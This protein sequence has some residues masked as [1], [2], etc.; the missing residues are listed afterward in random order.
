M[1]KIGII[2]IGKRFNNVYRDIFEKLNCKFYLWNR[3]E[4]KLNSFKNKENY[5]ILKSIKSFESLELDVCISFIP[6]NV[7]Y[8]ILSEL[9][10]NCNLLIE[11]PVTDQRWTKI[12]NVGVLEQWV[13]LPIEQM[14]EK[15]YN[16]GILSRPYWVFNDG[17]SFDYHAIAQLRKYVNQKKPVL[18]YG[19]MQNIENKDG[20]VD[21]SKKINYLNDEWTHGVATLEDNTIL[22][23]NFA[24]SCKM[25]NLKPTQLLK[26]ISID[27]SII[28]GRTHEMDNDY[29]RFEVR[30]VDENKNVIINKIEK[31]Y[32]NNKFVGLKI[33][34][35]N[36]F[37]K[38][39]YCDTPFNDQQIAI[40]D[41]VIDSTKDILYT[42]ENAFYDYITI[43][44]FKQSA[45]VK[46]IL[47]V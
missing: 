47:R 13:Y 7:N 43:N 35:K 34:D 33:E 11:T 3:T 26:A 6:S 40:A 1:L 22:M 19:N 16:A 17:R 46:N 25:T 20:Y 8:D 41:L 29:E 37:W 23:H 24:Y 32:E 39:N 14:K 18:F 10:L 44:A 5:E 42:P 27:G 30:Y 2:G 12:K 31:V 28:S 36:I 9:N 21:K 45:F 15:I 4:S 38:N